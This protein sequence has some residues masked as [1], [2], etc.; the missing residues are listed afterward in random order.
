MVAIVGIVLVVALRAKPDRA[1]VVGAAPPPA[2]TAPVETAKTAIEAPVTSVSP[3]P[4]PDPPPVV[5]KPADDFGD[6]V[7]P[8]SAAGH[9]VFVDGR[10]AGDGSKPLHVKRGKHAIKIGSSGKTQSIDVPCGDTLHL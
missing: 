3:A 10:V 2:T 9:R 6:I 1:V 4:S 5:A 8:P 7:L